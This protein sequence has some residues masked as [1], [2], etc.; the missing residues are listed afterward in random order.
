MCSY[1]QLWVAIG[2]YVQLC[3]CVAMCSY[4]YVWVTIGGYVQLWVAT[5]G[6]VQ[7]GVAMGGYRWVCV[8]I[9][10]FILFY[11]IYPAIITKIQDKKKKRSGEET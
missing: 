4:V 2:G 9:Y 5:G 10:L 1:V 7:L 8:A 6:Y 11:F 3:T